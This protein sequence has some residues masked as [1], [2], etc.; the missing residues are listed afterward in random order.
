VAVYDASKPTA[1]G[2]SVA[3][4]EI[5][6]TVSVLRKGYVW[7]FAEEAMAITDGVY[8]RITS[9]GGNTVLGKVRNDADTATA[10][11]ATGIRVAKA[12]TA[13][14]PVLL[15]VVVPFTS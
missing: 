13:A 4:Y 5:G 10:T 15:E 1:A 2:V 3:Q 12:C 11:L 14:G 8:V 9:S 6:E 7:A